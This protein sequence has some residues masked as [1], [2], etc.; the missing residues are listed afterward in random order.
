ML[1]Y[2]YIAF[3]IILIWIVLFVNKILPVPLFHKQEVLINPSWQM[4]KPFINADTASYPFIYL[5]M[6]NHYNKPAYQNVLG[7]LYF[8]D[9]LSP[10]NYFI[11]L[12]PN[13]YP[14]TK[15]AGYFG[16]ALMYKH[17]ENYEFMIQE[18]E[19]I[20]ITDKPYYSCELGWA[21]AYLGRLN[22]AIDCFKKEL[23]YKN[24]NK[25]SAYKGLA[26]VYFA[27][28]QTDE[29]HALMSEPLFV[30]NCPDY[31]LRNEYF[32]HGPLLTYLTFNLEL[33]G[34]WDLI[35]AASLIALLW[36]YYFTRFKLFV[37]KDY[38]LYFIVFI[39]SCLITPFCIVL[40]DILH[41]SFQ[42][43]GDGG[44]LDH[45]MYYIF[46]VGGIEEL[47]KAL[48]VLICVLVFSKRM[49]E[50]VDYLI[51]ATVSA[52]G[53]AFMENLMYFDQYYG[54]S[55]FDVIHNRS[56]LSVIM[57]IFCSTII[58]YGFIKT[59]M[60]KKI[61]YLVGCIVLSIVTH[62]M[63]DVFLTQSVSSVFY[64]FSFGMVVFS[65][66][67]LKMMYN[68]ALNQSPFFNPNNV[69]PANENAFI[70]IASLGMVLI[71]EFILDAIRFGAPH[72]NDS[73]LTSLLA[74]I[75]I[76]IIYSSNFARIVL[77]RN[78]WSSVGEMFVSNFSINRTVG[79]EVVLLTNKKSVNQAIYPLY[80][81][82]IE[83]VSIEESNHNY[84]IQLN[85][86][87]AYNGQPIHTLVA[88]YMMESNVKHKL[89][90]K[91]ITHTHRTSDGTI[92]G[93]VSE[94]TILD[95][96]T[97]E[98][99]E[100]K[101]TLF[102][103]INSSWKWLA[104]IGL[105]FLLFLY[106]FTKFMDYTT[107]IDYYRAAERSLEKLEI[108]TSSVHCR[109]ALNFNE[110]NYEARILF[111]KIRMDGGFYPE[112]LR[113]IYLDNIPDYIAPDYFAIR[114]VSQYKIGLYPQAL[115]S[116]NTCEMYSNQFDSL[117]WY[118]ANTCVALK[119]M[120]EATKSMNLFLADKNHQSK[121]AY[122]KIADLYMEQKQ[123]NEAY[124]YYDK[125]ITKKD[126]YSEALMKR[127]LC[128]YYL[129]K[130]EAACVDLETAHSYGSP[131]AIEYL[132]KWCRVG[133][134]DGVED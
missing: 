34:T 66:F 69:Y 11:D 15:N 16:H 50:P 86:P 1:R 64:V 96:C 43:Y 91:L 37:P 40:Y 125:L 24:G 123:Y 85:E 29:I 20:T 130:K 10:E 61:K 107:S 128:N 31:I 105:A 74:Y 57:H 5:T 103:T 52:L 62:G 109:S 53:F 30:K 2:F 75:A 89:V 27:L 58:W 56:V 13:S 36:G 23:T 129:N 12:K 25:S 33:Y 3:A 7:G 76:L 101:Q 83:L 112:A 114:G 73:L 127:G 63:Y 45:V 35:L 17:L 99:A 88:C 134:D 18:L 44:F 8:R 6:R 38:L 119:N 68:S 93:S 22:E 67:G 92:D 49:K 104:L 70:L 120:P 60:L 124:L 102:E 42:F 51:L 14:P 126:F 46:G 55:N 87:I 28:K 111:A 94:N 132:N 48:P 121:Y 41:F 59:R 65:F 110:D 47:T 54:N 115:Q 106:S 26:E 84:L 71:F 118:K 113:Y 122:M 131:N 77:C 108:Y 116:F 32:H 90:V 78:H 72:A 95:Y 81:K 133:E 21:N 79:S 98:T 4:P 117:Y 80:G 97:M 19:A 82:I 100:E 9:D 39:L